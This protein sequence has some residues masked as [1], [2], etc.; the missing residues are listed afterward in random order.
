MSQAWHLLFIWV[1]R[2]FEYMAQRGRPPKYATEQERLDALELSH[3]KTYLKKNNINSRD[4]LT[5]KCKHQ[6]INLQS[7]KYTV[8]TMDRFRLN[9]MYIECVISVLYTED[10]FAINKIKH[11]VLDTINNFLANQDIWDRKNKIYVFDAPE[12]TSK[13]YVS[14]F[15]N[16]N[17]ELH[18]RRESEP[19]SFKRNVDT[20]MP[21]VDALTES[22]KKTCA[23]TGL[24]LAYRPST[25]KKGMK[26]KEYVK[27]LTN[28]LPSVTAEP[29]AS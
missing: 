13:W 23:E 28:D 19:I 26:L 25:N 9:T 11:D 6:K 4:D 1:F 14:S 22:I 24:T 3:R 10:K 18:L 8:S 7:I 27:D 2:I 5:H 12:L 15:R 16:I 17:F 20:L 29:D 21:L